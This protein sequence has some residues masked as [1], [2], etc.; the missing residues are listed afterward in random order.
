MKK[1]KKLAQQLLLKITDIPSID[2]FDEKD[3]TLINDWLLMS[4]GHRGF[5]L[6][7]KA[8]DRGIAQSMVSL[9]VDTKDGRK[10]YN[11]FSG[12]RLEL[13]RLKARAEKAKKL[14]DS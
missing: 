7:I 12:R 11:D 10:N 8:R 3:M 2:D 13:V 6:Y 14:K 5:Y 4:S 1:I 9:D